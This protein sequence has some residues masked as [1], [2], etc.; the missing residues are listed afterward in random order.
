M[1]LHFTLQTRPSLSHNEARAW[2]E[3]VNSGYKISMKIIKWRVAT[4]CNEQKIQLNI[5]L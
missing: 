3:E 2:P 4:S 1:L 5:S